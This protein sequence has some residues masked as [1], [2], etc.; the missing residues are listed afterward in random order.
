VNQITEKLA[1]SQTRPAASVKKVSAQ[2]TKKPATTSVAPASTKSAVPFH[3]KV[4]D[5]AFG[6]AAWYAATED[7][8]LVSH[9]RGLNWS[10]VS[11]APPQ[12]SSPTPGMSGSFIRAVRTASSGSYIRAAGS[13][14]RW[15]KDVDFAGFAV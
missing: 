2:A 7:G 9:D 3:A 1:P 15:R 5:M 13:F 4:N 6:E 11:L 10:T 12:R 8:L 14:G